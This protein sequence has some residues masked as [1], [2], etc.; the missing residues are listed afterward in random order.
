MKNTFITIF[1]I[2]FCLNI[3]TADEFIT[4]AEK[5]NFKETTTYDETVEYCL[6][7]DS[8]SEMVHY[9]VIGESARGKD[10]P[11][12]IIDKDGF[13]SVDEVKN[14]G[15]AV[16]LVEGCIHAG[17]ADGKDALLMLARDIAIKKEKLNLI[18]NVT[19]LI[20]PIFNVDGHERFGKYHRINQN[21]PEE[22]GWRT[23]ATN[24]N[25][26]RDFLK[27]DAPVMK[28]LLK[29]F[30]KWQPDFFIDCHT[31]DGADYQ[32]VMTYIVQ[33]LGGIDE[34]IKSWLNDTYLDNLNPKMEESG[35]PMFPYVWF[36]NW[37]DPRSG[38]AR[39]VGGPRF[40]VG[41]AAVQN[42]PALLAETHMLKEYKDRVLSTYELLAHTLE[43][44]NNDHEN[45]IKLNKE[46]DERVASEEFRTEEFPVKYETSFEDSIMVDFEGFSYKGIESDLSGGTWFQY[47]DTPETMKI[48]F[49]DQVSVIDS[50]KLPE[51]YILPP[52]WHEVIERLDFHGIEYITIAEETELEVHSYKLTN[53][54]FGEQP[55]QGR[56][57][58]EADIEPIIE[59][60]KYPVGTLIIDM[61][62][63][64]ARVIAHIFEPAAPDSYAFWGFFNSIFERTEY[65]ETYVMEKMAREMLENN[66]DLQKEFE[67][68]KE[69]DK[70]FAESPRKIL[71][72]FYEKTP[73]WDQK[74]QKYPVGKIFERDIIESLR[75][76]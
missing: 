9:T 68:K 44:I 49:F 18:E 46:A 75:V 11:M 67:A 41:Y 55:F 33:N 69:N 36:R 3:S 52:E 74:Y 72:W 1:T 39:G 17:E 31:T 65:V 63:R 54:K 8:A 16:L 53:Q 29:T 50:V 4:K 34:N 12:L 76:R 5:T 60:R 40:S 14:S 13:K 19:F 28:S 47:S 61:N 56:F 26:N 15:K 48:P 57:T 25:L 71:Y 32:Y 70:E 51:A 6:K 42:R 20:V 58:V 2:L 37:H 45:L 27:A 30:N 59:K 64:T 23:T 66:P 43:I 10:L 35:Y 62:Q 73:Y 24:L 22:A 7:L 21:G 38:M